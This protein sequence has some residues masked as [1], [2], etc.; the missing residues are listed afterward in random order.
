MRRRGAGSDAV[1]A[2][3]PRAP[4]GHHTDVSIV[5]LSW[6]T[7]DLLLRCLEAVHRH[8]PPGEWEGVVVDNASGDGSAEAVAERFPA[9]TLVRNRRNEGYARGNNQ[10]IARTTG[11]LV[12]LLNSD[13]VVGEGSLDRLVRELRD[14]PRLA[15]AAPQLRNPDGTV[16]RSCMRFPSL[17]TALF[18][19]TWLERLFPGNPVNARYFYRDFDHEQTREVDQPP[20]A[21]LLLRRE[22]LEEV[23][24]LD[25]DL[26]LFFNDVDLCLRLRRAGWGIRFVADARVR[27]EVG[28]STRQFDDFIVTWHRN[29]LRYY[30]KHHGAWGEAWVR[31]MVRFRGWEESWRIRRDPAHRE[32]RG[33]ALAHVEGIVAR[34]LAPGETGTD[35]ARATPPVERASRSGPPGEVRAPVGGRAE[36]RREEHGRDD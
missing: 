7:R 19:D 33:A 11:D 29:R 1:P 16:Q 34:I 18:F 3:L 26:F 31:A 35:A 15:I 4:G 25:E 28:A 22:A 17:L 9:W 5:V 32:D 30:R 24:L 20:G 8:P 13:T 14:H 21:C 2:L 6:N 27:H 12:L 36:A 23:G 10:G